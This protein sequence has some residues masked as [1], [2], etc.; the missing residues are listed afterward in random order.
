[1]SARVRPGDDVRH[2]DGRTLRAV[3]IEAGHVTGRL[4]VPGW[5]FPGEL[6]TWPLSHVERVPFGPPSTEFEDAL[7]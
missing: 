1:M 5:V 4:I 7:L 3:V 6:T 2:R